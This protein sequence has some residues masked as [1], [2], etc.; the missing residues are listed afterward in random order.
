MVAG[1]V[2]NHRSD[3][4]VINTDTRGQLH[5]GGK[6]DGPGEQAAVHQLLLISSD[7]LVK[8]HFQHICRTVAHFHL[9][10]V[11]GE[12]IVGILLSSLT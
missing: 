8:C 12:K 3:T 1:P 6:G 7:R 11:Q 9:I 5:G 2:M 4:K 10:Q